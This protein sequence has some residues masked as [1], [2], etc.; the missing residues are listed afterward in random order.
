MLQISLRFSKRL[1]LLTPLMWSRTKLIG[2]PCHRGGIPHMAHWFGISSRLRT[3]LLTTCLA[4]VLTSQNISLSVRG[5][6]C[7]F[8]SVLG[9][10]IWEEGAPCPVRT[11]DLSLTR[12]MHY[13]CANGAKERVC[14]TPN[15]VTSKVR[16]L[17]LASNTL[18]CDHGSVVPVL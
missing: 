13:R 8:L 9:L 1:S 4:T 11:D 5:A 2:F 14:N 17:R 12:R 15:I 16:K 6:P 10:A 3:C 18:Q 7:W